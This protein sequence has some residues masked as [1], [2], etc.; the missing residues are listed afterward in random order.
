MAS[1]AAAAAR[2]PIPRVPIAAVVSAAAAASEPPVV[3][4]D[5]PRGSS[6]I[7][8]PRASAAKKPKSDRL[9]ESSPSEQP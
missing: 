6:G 2:P 5:T 4:A 9:D 1:A 8:T 7:E 3:A